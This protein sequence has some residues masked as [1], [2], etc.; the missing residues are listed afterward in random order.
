MTLEGHKEK[1]SGQ[2]VFQLTPH[3][4]SYLR[5]VVRQNIEETE[6]HAGG[7]FHKMSKQIYAKLCQ[8]Y[9]TQ[10]EINQLSEYHRL[11]NRY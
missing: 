4:L 7:R 6:I 1:S 2:Y 8:G 9:V 10:P 5:S 11:P 3:E